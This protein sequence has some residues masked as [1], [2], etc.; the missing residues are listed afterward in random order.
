MA[1]TGVQT[2]LAAAKE[3]SPL[4][5]SRL[6]GLTHMVTFHVFMQHGL[7]MDHVCRPSASSDA[8]TLMRL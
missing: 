3:Q 5:T 7:P 6:R 4:H 2:Q 8:Q 1:R